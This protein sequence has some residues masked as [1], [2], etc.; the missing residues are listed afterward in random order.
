[1]PRVSMLVPSTRTCCRTARAPCRPASGRSAPLWPNAFSVGSPCTASRNSSP[2]ALNAAAA[3]AMPGR[4]ALDD[5]RRHQSEQRRA[6]H[7][8]GDRHVPERD[9]G[10]D[11]QR[12][13]D[14]DRHL[15]QVL[16]EEGLQLLD[17]ID[18]RQHHAAGAF[19]AEPGRAERDDLVVQPAAQRLLH[20]GRGPV[21]DHG[22][23]HGR[24]RR[25]AGCAA[26]C[27][28]QRHDQFGGRCAAEQPGEELAEEDEARDADGQ[29]QQAEQDRQRDAPAQSR[30]MRHSL[31]SKCTARPPWFAGAS[32]A[33]RVVLR[34]RDVFQPLL[35]YIARR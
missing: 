18:H 22:A 34:K 32:W 21:R 7:H 14:G 19:G 29:R 4:C 2:N 17:A 25:A 28:D 15:R 5:S 9:E 20:P 16:A 26:Q 11:R 8:S 33:S 13:A 12:R 24:A 31:R 30:V 1:M 3:R 35:S 10:E 23:Q 6:Q 27:A